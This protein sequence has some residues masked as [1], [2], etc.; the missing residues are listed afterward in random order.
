MTKNQSRDLSNIC[1][2]ISRLFGSDP[3]SKPI[4]EEIQRWRE[5]SGSEWTLDRLKGL[6]QNVLL[7]FS[8]E[9]Y[10]IEGKFPPMEGIWYKKDKQGW[11]KGHLGKFMR[12][13]LLNG[14]ENKRGLVLS[15][16]SVG[17]AFIAP[18]LMETQKRK[19]LEAISGKPHRDDLYEY[20]HSLGQR[21]SSVISIS[22]GSTR[23]SNW[24]SEIILPKK[25]N[26]LKE[27]VETKDFSLA[28]LNSSKPTTSFQTSSMKKIHPW[29]YSLIEGTIVK[30]PWT[31]I[32]NDMG[33]PQVKTN[34][35]AIYGGR[36]TVIQ[37]GGL[38]A[39]VI[40]VPVAASQIAFKPL[41]MA[42]D[43]ILSFIQED[44]THN[45]MAG[46]EWSQDQLNLGKTLHAVDLSSATDN[47]PL[48]FQAAVLEK[49]GYYYSKEF[50]ETCRMD[51]GNADIG[52][53]IRY[54][55]G[56]PM[57]LYGSFSLFALSHHVLIK[58][59]ESDLGLNSTYRIL[60]DD[61]VISNEEVHT[62][63]RKAMKS[64]GVPISE[65]KC[66]TS[67]LL[68]EFAGKV[69]SPS[70]PINF[71]KPPKNN[72]GLINLDQFYNYCKV[73]NSWKDA[74]RGVPKNYR[75]FARSV[76]RLP[77]IYGGLGINPEGFSVEQRLTDFESS[78]HKSYPLKEDLDSSLLETT[79]KSSNPHVRSLCSFV[80]DQLTKLHDKVT[81]ELNSYGFKF[82]SKSLSRAVLGQI[83]D[84][85][86]VDD[87]LTH[88]G[89]LSNNTSNNSIFNSWKTNTATM[90]RKVEKRFD[91]VDVEEIIS[92]SPQ[93]W[94]DTT[95]ESGYGLSPDCY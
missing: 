80:S 15:I 10:M 41:H 35:K 20:S 50:V 65:H 17:S 1:K 75:K 49:L 71:C 66:L 2:H 23:P 16:L 27:R 30:G 12:T 69:V 9:R 73:T 76:V 67:D 25:F 91:A 13:T 48:G 94:D 56:Q 34:T 52:K 33:V 89:T 79:L 38:K 87:R 57:G 7:F 53:T 18:K 8:D 3:R 14:K 60:G 22:D 55:K 92:V 59:I 95:N 51:F 83:L 11:P 85:T 45:Q 40:G 19:F 78:K 62:R 47:F 24:G 82:S 88:A 72:Q 68:T 58:K 31:R 93:S 64:L 46:V 77:E 43:K 81:A 42:L 5:E 70:G 44:C 4:I 6:K 29:L 84:S 37:E 28:G 63:Y 90:Q 32:L 36:I 26:A 39:R 74:I 86:L 54:T 21:A 61:I